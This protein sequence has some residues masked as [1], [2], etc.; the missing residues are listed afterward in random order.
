M[1]QSLVNSVSRVLTVGFAVVSVAGMAAAAGEKTT[2]TPPKAP[3]AHTMSATP[4]KSTHRKLRHGKK[5]AT[6]TMKKGTAAKT[7]QAKP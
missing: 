2:M 5:H 6:M 1:K 4:K 3:A 7:P